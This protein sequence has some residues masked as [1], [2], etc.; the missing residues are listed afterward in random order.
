MKRGAGTP[1]VMQGSER[2]Q[3]VSCSLMEHMKRVHALQMQGAPS[4]RFHW[5]ACAAPTG[6]GARLGVGVRVE[7][8]PLLPASLSA[9]G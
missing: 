1:C 5:G 8:A 9:C 3:G 4:P 7:L 6:F 2:R